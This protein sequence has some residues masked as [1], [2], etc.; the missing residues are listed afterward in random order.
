M[1]SVADQ[2]VT[3]ADF[4]ER[5]ERD[6]TGKRFELHDGEII[7]VPPAQPIHIKLQKHIE[8]LLE[9]LAGDQGVVTTE[10]PYRPVQ[11]LQYW[12]ADVAYVL[13]A[14]WDALP[15]H[16]YPVYSPA[17]IVE[18][19]SPSN[20]PAKVNRQRIV[21]LSAGTQ[22]FWVVDP[23]SREVHVTTPRGTKS[24]KSGESIPIAALA[25]ATFMVDAIFAPM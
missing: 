14:D 24:F 2:L 25:G 10:F 16:E 7:L 19:L 22:E 3:W 1:G 21:A 4:L 11:N 8:R 13:Q 23:E 12:F 20:T 17:L 18:V 5:P 15:P 6:E 9:G